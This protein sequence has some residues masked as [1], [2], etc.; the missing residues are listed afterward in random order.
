[1][2]IKAWHRLIEEGTSISRRFK[3]SVVLTYFQIILEEWLSL[4]ARYLFL[5]ESSK[6][7]ITLKIAIF[8]QGVTAYPT[9]SSCTLSTNPVV[10]PKQIGDGLDWRNSY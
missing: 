9:Y 4:R 5:L 8:Y 10:V 3:D 2:T 7:I 6:N 1:M